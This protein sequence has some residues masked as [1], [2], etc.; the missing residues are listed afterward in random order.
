MMTLG[1]ASW[2]DPESIPELNINLTRLRIMRSAERLT[3][4][5]QEP[6]VQQIQRTDGKRE[7]FPEVFAE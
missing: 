7:L 4:V 1:V 6:A 2:L 5:E 3:I